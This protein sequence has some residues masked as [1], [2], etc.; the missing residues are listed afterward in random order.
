M[1]ATKR[2]A[3]AGVASAL[4][5]TFLLMSV[6]VPI[7]DMS[8]MILASLSMLLPIIK[9][10]YVGAGLC[11]LSTALLAFLLTGNIFGIL[12]F[13]IFFGIHPIIVSLL[14]KLRVP[15]PIALIVKLIFANIAIFLAWKFLGLA[16]NWKDI[17]IPYYVL[18]IGGSMVFLIY[19]WFIIRMK[20]FL[21]YYLSRIDRGKK[22]GNKR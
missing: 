18:A 9:N 15:I 14:I 17:P 5:T 11:Y 2:V 19:D 10:D 21:N 20:E 4:G 16:I 3:L 22:R 12:P 6:Y 13:A 7:L 1:K 8:C